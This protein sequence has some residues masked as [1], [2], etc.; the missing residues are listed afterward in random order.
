MMIFKTKGEV[1]TQKA[2]AKKHFITLCN[3]KAINHDF[4]GYMLCMRGNGVPVF[5][6]KS[7][8]MVQQNPAISIELKESPYDSFVFKCC[9]SSNGIL[10]KF[11]C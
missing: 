1:Q 5:Y 3:T 10:I 9:L 11:I 8:V 7:E 4:S 6:E 2:K